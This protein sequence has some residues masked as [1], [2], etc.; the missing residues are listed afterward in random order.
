MHLC[1]TGRR[2]ERNEGA[3]EKYDRENE[4]KDELKQYG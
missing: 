4:G 2:K 1:N 3:K